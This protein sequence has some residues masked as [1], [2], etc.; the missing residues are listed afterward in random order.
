VL[1]VLHELNEQEKVTIILITHYMEEVVEADK[2]FV[3][4]EGKLQM[5][6]TPREIFSQV[7]RLKEYRL[8]VPQ[9]TELAYELRKEGLNIRPGILYSSELISELKRI[10][11]ERNVDN[12]R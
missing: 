12:S 10:K 2:V 9:V 5:Q 6:G 7:E 11:E 4:H 3:I 1:K 8:D